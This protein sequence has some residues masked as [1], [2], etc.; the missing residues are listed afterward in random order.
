[1]RAFLKF[2]LMLF[3]FSL[4]ITPFPT[5]SLNLGVL[6]YLCVSSLLVYRIMTSGWGRKSKYSFLGGLRGAAQVISYEIIVL[7]LI[8][9]PS[10]LKKSFNFSNLGKGF[11]FKRLIFFPVFFF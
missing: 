9:F 4:I 11:K 8:F 10:V 3:L 5:I 6:L 7:T 2:F 1:M